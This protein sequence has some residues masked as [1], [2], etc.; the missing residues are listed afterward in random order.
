M[1]QPKKL[2]PHIQYSNTSALLEIDDELNPFITIHH[3]TLDT[4]NLLESLNDLKIRHCGEQVLLT[5]DLTIHE[6]QFEL[7]TDIPPRPKNSFLRK[8]F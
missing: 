4:H 6:N 2:T 1:Y 5:P 3:E 8:I 7:S